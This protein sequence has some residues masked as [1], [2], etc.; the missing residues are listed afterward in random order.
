MI[1]PY[2]WRRS[3]TLSSGW[4]GAMD[5]VTAGKK[6]AQQAFYPQWQALV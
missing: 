3:V 2:P 4:N 5:K 1:S 6:L